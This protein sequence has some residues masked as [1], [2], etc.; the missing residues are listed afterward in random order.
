MVK[1]KITHMAKK[2]Y[3]TLSLLIIFIVTAWSQGG[4]GEIKGTL[5]DKVTGDPI[6]FAN[7]IVVQGGVQKGGATTNFDGMFSIKPLEAGSY[8]LVAKFIGFTEINI[9]GIIVNSERTT[10][11]SPKMSEGLELDAIEI[12]F[13]EVPLISRDNTTTGST[14]SADEIKKI[15]TRNINSL[16]AQTGGVYSAD[17][18][19]EVNVLGS[20]SDATLYI[21][22]GIKIIGGQNIPQNSIEQLSVFTA[23]IPARYGDLT[24]GIISITTKGPSSSFYGGF[25]LLT[26][27]LTD[28]FNYNLL[29]AYVS[30]PILIKDKGESTQ[31]SILGF[32][33]SINLVTEKDPVR[34]TF[35]LSRVNDEKL[36]ELEN[37]PLRRNPGGGT[38][39]EAEF[40]NEDDIQDVDFVEN[41]KRLTGSVAAKVDFQPVKNVN[42]TFGGNANF[43]DGNDFNY[44]SSLLNYK[45]YQSRQENDARG[46]VRFTQKFGDPLNSEESSSIL[47]NAYYTIQADYSVSNV[48]VQDEFHGENI[49]DYGYIGKFETQRTKFYERSVNAGGGPDTVFHSGF[50]DTSVNFT[51]GGVNEVRENYTKQFYS[52]AQEDG[53]NPATL[54]DIIQGGGLVNGSNPNSIY[55]IWTAP[56]ANISSYG[57]SNNT[58]FSFKASAS[59]DIGNHALSFGLEYEQRTDRSYSLGATGLYSVARQ[60]LNLHLRE[61]DLANPI[62]VTN[63]DGV[64]QDTVLYNR[65]VDKGNQTDFDRNLRAKLIEDKV[66]INGELVNETT[67]IDV[68]NLDPSLLD[69]SLYGPDDLFNGGTP[70]SKLVNYYGY[71]HLGNKNTARVDYLDFF[72]DEVNR[73]IGPNQPIYIAGYLED[74][75]SFRDL[76]FRLGVRVERYDANTKVLTDRFSLYP[77]RT[78]GEVSSLN[79]G[80]SEVSH[81]DNV[82][83]DFVVYVNNPTNPN[84]IIG[85]RSGDVFYDNN[86]NAIQQG[87]EDAILTQALEINGSVPSGDEI[88]PYISAEAERDSRGNLTLGAPS[89]KDYEPQVSVL[90]RIAF[91]FPISDE[92]LFFANYDVL[93]QRPTERTLTNPDDYF[94]L[95]TGADNSL[96]NPDLRPTRSINYQIG[97]QQKLNQRSAIKFETFYK[98]SRDNIQVTNLTVAYPNAYTTFLNI[99]FGTAKGLVVTYDLRRAGES[100]VSAN[101]NYTLTFAEGTGSGS[102]AGAN[103]ATLGLPNLRV[104]TALDFDQRHR[105]VARIDYRYGEGK[106]YNGPEWGRNVLENFGVN[107]RFNLGSGTPFTRQSNA[108]RLADINTDQRLRALDGSINGSRLPWT[109]RIDLGIDKQ[110]NFKSEDKSKNGVGLNVYA[111]VLNVFNVR[112][113]I[114]VYRFTGNPGDDGYL[115]SAQGISTIATQNNPES[116]V[117]LYT[118]KINNPFNYSLPRFIRIGAQISF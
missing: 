117:A 41:V 31:R 25:E 115:T 9:P 26:S 33:A 35:G 73:P 20:R 50:V 56:G 116:F 39:S 18:G 86:G 94:F 109:S 71:D 27:Q 87:R 61:L 4:N 93:S 106:K 52:F 82:G 49:F 2:L 99:D 108:L 84:R 96:N 46:F 30:G 90:P 88:A 1:T 97:F 79:G 28:K 105:V 5:T 16:A 89:F 63:S 43:R 118:E 76:V 3:T 83:D 34:R 62:Y 32:T 38:L 14:V 74:R 42:I 19:E 21:V 66:K 36:E 72:N 12:V 8:T 54:N 67:F 102:G 58:Q 95:E 7:V 40:L 80:I 103:L 98:E 104:P 101:I 17:E 110:F 13:Y 6:P 112:N 69:L 10:F 45:N 114:T 64:F 48:K 85:Y 53:N 113:T 57:Y 15:P 81:P 75:F 92:A 55:S 23:G 91:S 29:E 70:T 47:K 107:L 77:V 24:G 100:N 68:D 22:D 59:S 11:V 65:F 44:S 60:Q 51:P 78:V 111:Q 37:A